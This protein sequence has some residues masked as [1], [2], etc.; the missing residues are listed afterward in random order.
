MSLTV[1]IAD[2]SEFTR[3]LLRESLAPEHEI[4]GEAEHGKQAVDMFEEHAPDLVLMDIAMP[5]Q[6]GI[7]ATE[8]IKARDEDA[9]VIVCTS[10]DQEEMMKEAIKVGANGYITKP[11]D[12]PDVLEAIA[13]VALA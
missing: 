7:E 12:G 8:A 9:K 10:V 2:D 13:D 4:V 11:F 5:Y 6:N 1:L 3:E